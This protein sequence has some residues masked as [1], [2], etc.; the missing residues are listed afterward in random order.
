[1][2]RLGVIGP[3]VATVSLVEGG[4]PTR[5]G[6]DRRRAAPARRFCLRTGRSAPRDGRVV[7][8]SGTVGGVFAVQDAARVVL[9]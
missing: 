2:S 5:L 7:T 6:H 8:K 1:M 3:V 4:A 9:V